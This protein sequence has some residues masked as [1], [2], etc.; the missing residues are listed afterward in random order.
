MELA[1]RSR[2]AGA[3]PVA[4]LAE[5]A[6]AYGQDP[7][8]EILRLLTLA[9]AE[10][11]FTSQGVGRRSCPA[12]RPPLLS[13]RGC[14]RALWKP[15][16]GLPTLIV[17]GAEDHVVDQRLWG[18]DPAFGRPPVLRSTIEG[19]AHFPWVENPGAVRAAFAELTASLSRAS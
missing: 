18:E 15:H 19:A 6:D 16:S 8:D 1:V 14:L 7:N 3:H 5:A 2:R 9:A 13:R 17:S 11:N 10:W 4:G 12:G